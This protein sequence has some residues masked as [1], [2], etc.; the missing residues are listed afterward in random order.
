MSTATTVEQADTS[1]DDLLAMLSSNKPHS[2]GTINA[3]QVEQIETQAEDAIEVSDTALR[4]DAWSRRRGEEV[5][6]D[7]ELIRKVMG[8]EGVDPTNMTR[9]QREWFKGKADQVADFH[10]AAFEPEPEVAPAAKNERL[11]QYMKSLMETPEFQA[12]HAETQLDEE[13]SEYAAA[14]YAQAWVALEATAEKE[15]FAGEMQCL[16]AAAGALSQA[17]QQVVELREA[18]AALGVKE[19]STVFKAVKDSQNLKRILALAGRYRRFAQAQQ[20]KKVRHG[21]DDVVGVVLDNDPGRIL[22]HELASLADPDLEL[23]VLRRFVERGLMSREYRGIERQAKG[24]IV[25]VVDESGSMSGEPI[26]T[27]KAIA[28][29]LAWVARSQNRWICLVGFADDAVGNWCVVPPTNKDPEALLE[30]LD[31][32]YNGGTSLE[33]LCN[34][35]PKRWEEIGAPKGKTDIVLITDAQVGLSPQDRKNFLAFKQAESVKLISLILNCPPGDVGSISDQ[36][37]AVRSLSLEEA[38]VAEALSV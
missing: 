29:A 2:A 12:L 5:L 35:L 26:W 21:R 10:A 15:G 16:N 23:D 18:Q 28:L 7:S 37:H 14:S 32:F 34:T 38:G 30:W 24:P 6:R 22:P 9:D 8:G 36:V 11:R 19:V 33:V 17:Q 4:L 25:L 20:R 1:R 13:A 3:L 31:H 27:A